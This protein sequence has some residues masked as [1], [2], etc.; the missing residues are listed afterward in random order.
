MELTGAPDWVEAWRQFV[1]PGDVV[2]L[3]LN[4]VGAPHIISDACVVR[5]VIAGLEAAGVKRQDIVAYDRYRDEFFQAGFDKW[6]P[7]GVRVSHAAGSDNDV[8]QDM[9]GMT[10]SISLDLPLTLPGY[11]VENER[12]RRSYAA[13]FITQEVNKLINLPLLKD[14]QSAGITMSLKNMSTGW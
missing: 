1:Q 14:H 8:Q 11:P 6:L 7:E 4:P 10:R 5:E 13:R 9:K 12:A 2:G 3:K